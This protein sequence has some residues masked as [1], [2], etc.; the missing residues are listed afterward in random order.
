MGD[1][2]K[3]E[4]L[5]LKGAHG[6]GLIG[7]QK[8][9]NADASQGVAKEDLLSFTEFQRVLYKWHFKSCLAIEQALKSGESHLIKNAFL[10]LRQFMPCFPAVVDHGNSIIKIVKRLSEEEK[11]EFLDNKECLLGS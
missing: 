9:W 11:R 7:F 10:V 6:D 3:D 2:H 4:K 5:Y 8:N 1:W